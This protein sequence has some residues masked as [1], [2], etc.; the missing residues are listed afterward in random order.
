MHASIKQATLTAITLSILSATGHAQVSGVPG[1]EMTLTFA[2]TASATIEGTVE[3]DETGKAKTTGAP[4]YFNEWTKQDKNG[5]I[6]EEGTEEISK[7]LKFKI[8]NKEILE[9]LVAE[10][11][12]KSISGWSFKMVVPANAPES[13][14]GGESPCFYIAKTGEAPIYL[15]EYF[16]V[17][18]YASAESYKRQ[19]VE[20][21]KYDSLGNDAGSTHK[22]SGSISS[23]TAAYA[24]FSTENG[25]VRDEALLQING[26]WQS[27]VALRQIGGKES[28]DYRW[29][30]GSSKLY[31]ISG[32]LLSYDKATGRET[33]SVVEGSWTASS[34]TI[35][36]ISGFPEAAGSGTP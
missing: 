8:S 7:V 10:G 21:F 4:A 31:N 23:T 1:S 33:S 15:G 20:K 11:V 35:T 14:G 28:Q 25:R 19:A 18:D 29:I 27:S 24:T 2:M 16:E 36:D 22:Q 17:W 13:E 30:Q 5:N 12:I 34:K 6:A 3:K 26:L 32:D 9:M